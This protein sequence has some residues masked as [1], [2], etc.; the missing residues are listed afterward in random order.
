MGICPIILTKKHPPK[1][2]G[3]AGSMCTLFKILPNSNISKKRKKYCH[4]PLSKSPIEV[5]ECNFFRR[6]NNQEE[7]GTAVKNLPKILFFAHFFLTFV[8]KNADIWPNLSS[9][10]ST[11]AG[12]LSNFLN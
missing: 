10:L 3:V 1:N 5:F 12:S 9:I 4:R 7:T 6:V 11:T 2:T 8:M